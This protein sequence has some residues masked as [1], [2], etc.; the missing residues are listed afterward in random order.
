[1]ARQKSK[2]AKASSTAASA[3][4]NLGSHRQAGG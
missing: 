3:G 4:E 2:A 1:M